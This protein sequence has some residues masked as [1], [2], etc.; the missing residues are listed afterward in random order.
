[1]ASH[2]SGVSTAEAESG[3]FLINF[4]GFLS[5]FGGFLANS[6]GFLANF[7]DLAGSHSLIEG[8]LERYF[9]LSA[10]WHPLTCLLNQGRS[11]RP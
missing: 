2:H 7:G 10:I 9:A 1:M 8:S 3:E 5:N 11:Q 6:A 4:G